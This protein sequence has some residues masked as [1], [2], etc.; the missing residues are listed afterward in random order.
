MVGGF[1]LRVLPQEGKVGDAGVECL[2]ET[3]PG[4][5]SFDGLLSGGVAFGFKRGG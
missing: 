5:E 2:H 1:G 3:L 4:H